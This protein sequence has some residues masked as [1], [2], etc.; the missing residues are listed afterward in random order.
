MGGA[1]PGVPEALRRGVTAAGD[2]R[3]RLLVLAVRVPGWTLASSALDRDRRTG[4]GLLAGALA[5]RLFGALLPLALLIA[6]VFGYAATVERTAPE[7]AGEAIGIAPAVLESIAESSKLS[8]GTRWVVACGAL[9]ALLWSSASAARA[10]RAAHSLAWEG[11][12]HRLGRPVH[13]AGMLIAIVLALLGVWALVEAARTHLGAG[14][15][16]VVAIVAI[17]PLF[18]IWLGAS[19]LLPHGAAGW[20]A[21]IPGAVLVAIGL[22][23]LHFGTALFVAGKIERASATYGAFGVAFTILL[24]LYVLSRIIVGSAMLNAARWQARDEPHA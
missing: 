20:P 10:I 15:G 3:D 8:T 1:R 7:D 5:F 6:V 21:L 9:L 12:V 14:P 22:E 16:L 2:L 18:G 17:V 4:G 19:M 13:A 24:W 11:G 23:A